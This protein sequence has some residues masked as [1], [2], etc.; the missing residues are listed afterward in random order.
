MQCSEISSTFLVIG[1][2]L[3][4]KKLQE[5]TESPFLVIGIYLNTQVSQVLVI[6]PFLVIGGL[7]IRKLPLRQP[8]SSFP[9]NRGLSEDKDDSMK[10]F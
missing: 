5:L 1:I 9:C 3:Q 4:R 8:T 10:N 6:Y 2:Y 7:S